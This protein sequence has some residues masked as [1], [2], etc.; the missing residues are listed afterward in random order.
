[1]QRPPLLLAPLETMS[2]EGYKNVLWIS[3]ISYWNIENK[4]TFNLKS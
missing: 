3:L 1:M 2:K 4:P